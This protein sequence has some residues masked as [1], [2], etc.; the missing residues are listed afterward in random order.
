MNR[1]A[2]KDLLGP[3]SALLP[4]SL[5]VTPSAMSDASDAKGAY[6]LLVHL[7]A[8]CEFVI[9]GKSLSLLAGWHVY[10][11]SARGPG[12]MRARLCRHFRP[13]KPI[14]WHI[15][16]LTMVADDMLALALGGGVE[17]DIAARLAGSGL[18]EHVLPGFGSSD[19]K[20]C[21]SHLLVP[22][23]LPSAQ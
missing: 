13:Q 2:G 23:T 1:G 18:F 21:P 19:C 17:C 7:C 20:T 14:H 5:L 12:G 3:L 15:D 6:A 4:G 9:R 10:V 11:G 8:P 16:R 22:R